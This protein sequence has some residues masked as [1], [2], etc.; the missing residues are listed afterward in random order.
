MEFCNLRKNNPEIGDF[1]DLLRATR[2]LLKDGSPLRE[3]RVQIA[4]MPVRSKKYSELLVEKCVRLVRLGRS[5][6][7]VN[8]RTQRVFKL[9]ESTANFLRAL[10]AGTDLQHLK[11]SFAW[12]HEAKEKRKFDFFTEEALRSFEERGFLKSLH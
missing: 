10:L 1:I 6:Y 4:A 3:K 2:L 9:N 11:M 7:A 8:A 12:E 5:Q